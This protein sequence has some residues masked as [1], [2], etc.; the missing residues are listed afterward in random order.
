VLDAQ[1][2]ELGT[3]RWTLS[4]GSLL[5]H[6]AGE[7]ALDGPWLALAGRFARDGDAVVWR[8]VHARLDL[9]QV[10][11]PPATPFG[12]PG[13]Q[14]Q[15]RMEHATLRAGWPESLHGRLDWRAARFTTT[16]GAVPLGNLFADVDADHGVVTAVLGDGGDGPLQLAGELRISPLGWRLDAT[17]TPRG[18]DPALARWLA[19]LGPP[20]AR[21]AVHLQRG[22]GLGAIP[23]ST[24]VSR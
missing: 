10:E 6:A 21:G 16:S 13:G 18:D 5:G 22:A 17:L 3:L 4:R 11:P 24:G 1:G 14:W 7:V 2:R 8:D 20:D 23:A 15:V 9:A 19:R 12:T